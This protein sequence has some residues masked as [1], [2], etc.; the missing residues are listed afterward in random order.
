MRASRRSFYGLT[1]ANDDTF[2]EPHNTDELIAM[3]ANAVASVV[4]LFLY[5][6]LTFFFRY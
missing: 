1:R 4:P 2:R 3:H 6:S 5:V